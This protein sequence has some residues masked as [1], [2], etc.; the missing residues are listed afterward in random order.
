MEQIM[1]QIQPQT[2]KVIQEIDMEEVA[3]E[4]VESLA[5]QQVQQM[6]LKDNLVL[7]KQTILQ[8]PID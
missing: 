4:S 2:F 8:L 5:Q 7:I 1:Q 6:Q 3:Q